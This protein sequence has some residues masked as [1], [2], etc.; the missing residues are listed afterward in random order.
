M[1]IAENVATVPQLLGWDAARIARRV[2]ELLALVDMDPGALP[3]S[4]SARALGRPE[5]ARRRRARARRRSAGDADGRAVRRA[6]SDHARARCRTNSCDLLC[7]LR[8]TI[9][10]VTHD[11]DEAIKMGT[12]IAIL[13]A[14]RARAVR[15]ARGDTRAPRRCVRRGVRRQRPRAEAV[16]AA[17]GRTLCRRGSTAGGTRPVVAVDSD[18][19]DALSALLAADVDMAAVIDGA[20]ANRGVITLRAIRAALAEPPAHVRQ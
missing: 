6:R 18:L 13:R 19:R 12:R 9:V 2:D 14:G 16:G 4:L 7:E 3:R 15:P 20:G 17:D 1:T 11:I 8:K 5:A 10:F